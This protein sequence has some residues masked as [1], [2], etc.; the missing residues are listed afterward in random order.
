MLIPSYHTYLEW[1]SW[2]INYMWNYNP[3]YITDVWGMIIVTYYIY[4]PEI[5][6]DLG[7]KPIEYKLDRSHF[8]EFQIIYIYI[9]KTKNILVS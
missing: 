8:Y 1:Y 9:T 3:K 2:F 7:L 5:I 4:L 6:G